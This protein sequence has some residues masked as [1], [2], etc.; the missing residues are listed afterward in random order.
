MEKLNTTIEQSGKEASYMSIF[1]TYK[2]SLIIGVVV[3]MCQPLLGINT[4]MYYGPQI[5]IDSGIIA[6]GIEI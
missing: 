3:L 6:K 4:I 5:I 1:T 2:K